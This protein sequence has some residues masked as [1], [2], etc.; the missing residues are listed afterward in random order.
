MRLLPQ[1][2]LFEPNVESYDHIVVAFSGGKDSV[3]CVLALLDAGAD[4]ARMELWHHEVDGREGSRLMDWPCTSAY[5]RAFGEAFGLPVYFTWKEG[6]F[7]REMNRM[8]SRTAP[9]HFEAPQP[10][11]TVA[12]L[13]TGGQRGGE[14]TRRAFPQVANDLRVRWCSGYLKIDNYRTAIRNQ[15]RFRS[16]RTLF[17]SGE[18]A[19][20]SP[21]RAGYARFERDDCDAPRLRRFVDRYRPV[22]GWSEAEVWAI[23][24]RYRVNPHPAYRIGFGRCSCAGCIFGGADQFAT[25]KAIN[26]PQFDRLAA[27]EREFG[28]TMKRTEALPV[29][30]DRGRPYPA[31]QRAADVEAALSDD[32]TEAIILEEWTLPAGAFGDGC[33]PT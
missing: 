2:A 14:T 20:E 6:G 26:R 25:L 17:V 5:V 32:W 7:E 30:A 13:T 4:P 18:R 21:A 10:D 22:H 16:S 31:S 1:L 12:V 19:A 28:R 15:P 3:A 33:G 23:I 8:A 27:Y 29:L 11:G 9:I 24:E